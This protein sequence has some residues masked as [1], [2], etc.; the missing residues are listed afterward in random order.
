MVN[1]TLKQSGTVLEKIGEVYFIE[2]PNS[3]RRVSAT[4]TDYQ[5]QRKSKW[6]Q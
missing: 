4:L 2:L 5:I 3:N 6:L 1:I